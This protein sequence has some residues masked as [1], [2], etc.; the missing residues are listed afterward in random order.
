PALGLPV[1][2]MAIAA[3]SENTSFVAEA[4]SITALDS[5][6]SVSTGKADISTLARA[7]S[8]IM[9][10]DEPAIEEEVNMYAELS[11]AELALFVRDILD[12]KTTIQCQIDS[13]C[14]DTEDM[15]D[16]IAFFDE[17]LSDVQETLRK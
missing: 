12:L 2:A 15:T 6:A 3:M 10:V 11:N 7:T 9:T 4:E 1:E 5:S 14:E 8:K 13:G 17:I 16:I